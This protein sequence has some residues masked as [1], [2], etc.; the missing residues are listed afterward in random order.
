ML[1]QRIEG[2]QGDEQEKAFIGAEPAFKT[3]DNC[4]D[5]ELI[6]ELINFTYPEHINSFRRDGP[7]PFPPLIWP[8]SNMGT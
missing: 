4:Y 6:T 8:L 5:Q 2:R 1:E 3:L 7:L